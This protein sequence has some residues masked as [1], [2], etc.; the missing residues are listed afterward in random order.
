MALHWSFEGVKDLDELI[1]EFE[2]FEQ[3]AWVSLVIGMDKITRSNWIEFYARYRS[4]ERMF[5]PCFSERKERYIYSPKFIK[6]CI[7][8]KTNASTKTK[9]QFAKY[10]FD[11]TLENIEAEYKA[12]EDEIEYISLL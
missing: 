11:R 1:E 6:R 3:L 10:L 4:M 5:E 12:K 7:G 8:F 9:A 2:G